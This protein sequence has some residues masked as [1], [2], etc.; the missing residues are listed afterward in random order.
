MDEFS[1]E[2]PLSNWLNSDRPT[3]LP[4]LIALSGTLGHHHLYPVRC[5]TSRS[6]AGR[7]E[8]DN[9]PKPGAGK[10]MELSMMGSS[11]GPW[12]RQRILPKPLR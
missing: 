5:D 4:T 7:L 2:E 8:R 10:P 11:S 12:I 3:A 6:R 1:L 9:W